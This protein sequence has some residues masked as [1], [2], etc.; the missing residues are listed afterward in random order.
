MRRTIQLMRKEARSLVLFAERDLHAPPDLLP[1]SRAVQTIAESVP[2]A[3]IIPVGIRYAMDLHERPEAYLLL[4]APV[5][6]GPD[7]SNRTREAVAKLLEQSRESRNED[8]QI[9]AR[10]TQDVNERWD[11]RRLGKG[12]R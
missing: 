2:E 4:G 1:F 9:L 8:W 11:M 6:H 5:E 7:L 3:Q 12:P 10:G